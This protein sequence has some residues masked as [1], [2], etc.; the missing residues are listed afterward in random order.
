MKELFELF[1]LFAKMGSVTFGGGYAMLPILQRELV[2][3]RGWVTNEELA[4][5]YAVGQCTPGIIAVNTSTF[6]GEK[7]R[8]VVGGIASTLGFVFPSIIIISLIAAFL[9]NFAEL[10]VVRNA[11][12]GIQAC[13]CVLILNAVVKLMKGAVKNVPAILIYLAVLA[14][15]VFFG[16]SPIILVVAS[17]LAGV[18]VFAARGELK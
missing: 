18:A 3:K 9:S 10:A 11:F 5:Y 1:W 2:E 13:V 6:I 7:R 14:A 15:S 16:L 4:D 12:A 8:G 17:G